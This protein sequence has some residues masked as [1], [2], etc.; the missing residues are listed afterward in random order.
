MMRT[1]LG[2]RPLSASERH[3]RHGISTGGT[4][5]ATRIPTVHD[6]HRLPAVVLV[7][8]SASVRKARAPSPDPRGNGV[9]DRR[10]RAPRHHQ[11][12]PAV[13]RSQTRPEGVKILFGKVAQRDPGDNTRAGSRVPTGPPRPF[14]AA[15]RHPK[16]ARPDPRP[17]RTTASPLRRKGSRE[18]PARP[19][20][21]PR[22]DHV[23]Q[24]V[25]CEGF[26]NHPPFAAPRYCVELDRDRRDIPVTQWTSVIVP[27]LRS[28]RPS[29]RFLMDSHHSAPV[30]FIGFIMPRCHETPRINPKLDAC[31]RISSR[32]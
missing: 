19:A 3:F 6:D 20:R 22:P 26:Q 30:V 15:G 29:A 24:I 11:G 28:V 1:T 23:R 13:A 21:G 14:P 2:A 12:R 17:D 25:V 9:Q 10:L 5:F 8:P 27:D 7:H 4:R 31:G 18:H 16:A 32:K